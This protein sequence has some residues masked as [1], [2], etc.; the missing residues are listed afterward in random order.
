[1]TQ[2]IYMA[3]LLASACARYTDIEEA[4]LLAVGIKNAEVGGVKRSH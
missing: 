3:D 1:M 2:S 4:F